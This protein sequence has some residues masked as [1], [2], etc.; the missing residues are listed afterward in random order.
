[1]EENNNIKRLIQ[2]YF[3][4]RFS[5]SGRILFGRWLRAEDGMKE[6]TAAAKLL[7]RIGG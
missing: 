3:G 5:R 2:L 4:K 7:G 1:M 6:K